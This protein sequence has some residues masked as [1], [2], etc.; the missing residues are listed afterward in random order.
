LAPEPVPE[1]TVAPV[2]DSTG[3]WSSSLTLEHAASEAT[4]T[5]VRRWRW[6][7]FMEFSFAA[8]KCA[9]AACG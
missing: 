5:A 4:A 1:L 7:A 2:R 6:K 8:E 9:A 3:A